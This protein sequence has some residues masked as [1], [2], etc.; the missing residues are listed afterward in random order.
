MAS[1][2]GSDWSDVMECAFFGF[3]LVFWS[4][5]KSITGRVAL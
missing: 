2:S 4:R 1:F 5:E 3:V